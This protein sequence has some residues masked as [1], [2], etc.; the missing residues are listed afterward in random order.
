MIR[1]ACIPIG[2]TWTS[3]FV[4]WQGSL[5]EMP[6]IDLAADVTSR[7]LRER[8]FP[9]EDVASIVLGTTIPNPGLFYGAP[10]VAARIGA[11]GITGPMISQACATGV[12]VAHA[13]ALDVVGGAEGPV[14]G[15]TA[16]R[17][18]NS[19]MLV[20]PSTSGVGGSPSTEH[21]LLQAMA[22]DPWAGESML[23]TAERVAAESG[24][25][26]EELDE[27][28]LQRYEQYERALDDDRAF[29]RRY[30]VPVH[31][32]GR[33]GETVVEADEGVHRTTPEGL[34]KLAPVQPDGVLTYGSQTHPAD[35]AAG[36]VVTTEERARELS[37][38]G[39][40]RLLGF[41]FA[42]VGKA[43]MPKAAVPAA[44]N[45]LAAAELSIADVD[46]VTTHNPFV[47]NDTWFSQ[48]T[49]FPLDR[50]NTYGC[51][52]IYGHPHSAT[53]TRGIAELIE[54][55]RLRGGGVGLFTGCAAGD[56]GGAVVLRVED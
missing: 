44:Q 9:A 22:K 52:L 39:V 14:L 37:D 47:V 49:G 2:F 17:L 15:V 40:V 28:T 38:E 43:E 11:P 8:G 31:V 21:W 42:R 23:T 1:R 24:A 26:R 33:K 7:A 50:M 27:L 34:A 4:R 10:T 3:P 36:L 41:G 13:A 46:L 55:L 48:Q 6:T 51:S 54:A 16:D 53:G 20:Y 29:Q 25:T 18:S 35:A 12:A 19:P 30:M 5:G 56:T 45:A 32:P